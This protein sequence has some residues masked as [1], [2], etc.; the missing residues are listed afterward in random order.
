MRNKPN[1]QS[2]KIDA[3]A[4]R[5]V[6][7]S[8]FVHSFQSLVSPKVYFKDHPEC[9][10]LVDGK[11]RGERSQVRVRLCPIDTCDSHP[12]RSAATTTTS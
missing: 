8:P 4:G 10:S 9:F 2:Q 3:S 11:R 6:T 7:Y 1:G 12:S 5:K